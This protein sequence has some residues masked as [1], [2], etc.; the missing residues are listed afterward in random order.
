MKLGSKNQRELAQR[1]S[2]EIRITL[3]KTDECKKNQANNCRK[4]M[5]ITITNFHRQDL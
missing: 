1:S 4:H 3:G 5:S 2:S